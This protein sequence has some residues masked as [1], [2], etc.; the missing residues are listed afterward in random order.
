MIT[1]LMQSGPD[2]DHIP[3]EV[4]RLGSLAAICIGQITIHR[5]DLVEGDVSVGLPLPASGYIILGTL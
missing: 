1:Q 5:Q 4:D 3:R 2:P